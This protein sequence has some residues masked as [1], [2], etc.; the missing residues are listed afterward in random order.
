MKPLEKFYNDKV[1]KKKNSNWV[2]NYFMIDAKGT[3]NQHISYWLIHK[4]LK[5]GQE[6]YSQHANDNTITL[7]R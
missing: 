6:L 3:T 7:L 4:L 2:K 5:Q 1:K